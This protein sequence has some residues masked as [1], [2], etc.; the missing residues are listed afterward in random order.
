MNMLFYISWIYGFMSFSNFWK[1]S[2][3]FFCIFS[4]N[5]F[6]CFLSG[7]QLGVWQMMFFYPPCH[8]FPLHLY[9]LEILHNN[10]F[11]KMMID[12]V[13]Y[14]SKTRTKKYP[15]NLATRRPLV[16]L[17]KR[18]EWENNSCTAKEST[19]GRKMK[20]MS[21]DFSF[22]RHLVLGNKKEK[23]K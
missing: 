20:T 6:L 5:T 17:E 11:L 15:S 3:E 19:G 10:F 13:R 7:Y 18:W 22:S 14:S 16:T 4:L 8:L 12:D 1:L 2:G 23:V 21:T 9:M